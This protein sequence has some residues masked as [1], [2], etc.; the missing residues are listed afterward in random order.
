MEEKEDDVVNNVL[1]KEEREAVAR[2]VTD[3]DADVFGFTDLPQALIA[4]LVTSNSRSKLL[5]RKLLATEFLTDTEEKTEDFFRKILGRYGDDSVQEQNFL[6]IQFEQVSMLLAKQLERSRLVSPI[7]K[8]TRYIPFH[9]K[10]AATGLF[11]FYRGADILAHNAAYYGVMVANNTALFERYARWLPILKAEIA[12]R[13]TP[14][15]RA[16]MTEGAQRTAVRTRALDAVRLVLPAGTL[17]NVGVTA[18]ARALE[19]LCLKLQASTVGEFAACG[20]AMQPVFRKLAPEFLRRN[21]AAVSKFARQSLEYYHDLECG[22]RYTYADDARRALDPSEFTVQ[23][24]CWPLT[25]EQLCRQIFWR[26]MMPRGMSLAHMQSVTDEGI[27]SALRA[28]LEKRAQRRLHPPR[29]FECFTLTF[30]L[31]T[32]YKVWCDLQRHRIVSTDHQFLGCN[33][34][35]VVPDVIRQS[36]I[37]DEYCETM[38]ATRALYNDWLFYHGDV[39]PLYLQYMVPMG[40][41]MRWFWEVN[42]RELFHILELRSAPEGHPTYRRICKRIHELLAERYPFLASL[43][44]FMQTQEVAFARADSA[45][46]DEV[47]AAAAKK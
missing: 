37:F 4:L 20:R 36:T 24:D 14:A 40:F 27:R 12:A 26:R 21:D 2:Y 31:E 44:T 13:M 6:T 34:G 41:K 33:L 11:P 47:N 29:A 38:E 19:M 22:K 8:S 30:A 32:D 35:Y 23:L 42:L 1:T 39:S 9:L 18:N 17:T 43:I 7:E 28:I 46:R 5:A 16:S 3:V 25:E 15:E 10:D 45:A